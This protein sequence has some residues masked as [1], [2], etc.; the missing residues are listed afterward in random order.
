LNQVLSV[1]KAKADWKMT[2]EG[3]TD[4][5]GGEAFNKTLSDKRANA[6]KNYLVKNGIEATRL[7]AS[8]IG[9]S[10]PIATND[11]E[12]GRSQNRRVELVKK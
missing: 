2:I 10:K 9:L 12:A 1:L 5:I 6:V 11:T 7:T 4:N 8:G 3:H